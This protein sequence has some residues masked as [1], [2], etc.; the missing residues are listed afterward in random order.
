MPAPTISYAT[1]DDGPFRTALIRGLERLAGRRTLERH[2]AAT[3]SLN[4]DAFWAAALDRLGVTLDVGPS[5]P[6][7]VLPQTG[8]VLVVANHPFG[9]LD[10]LALCALVSRVRPQFRILVNSAL[11]RDERMVHHFL[12]IDFSDSGAARRQNV[13]SVKAAFEHLGGGGCLVMFPAGGVA[14]APHPLTEAEDLDWSPLVARLVH[15]AEAPVVPI[16]FDGQNSRLFQIASQVS[17]PLRLGLLIRETLNKRGDALSVRIK[18]RRPYR[19][20]SGLDRDVLTDR[21]RE[22]TIE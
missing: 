5:P 18:D 16:Y 2:Y 6:A 21:L 9:V 17:L 15:E 19:V 14:T 3:Q 13:R 7:S 10:G 22:D 12:P 8:P 11:C 20:L 1:P 4:L